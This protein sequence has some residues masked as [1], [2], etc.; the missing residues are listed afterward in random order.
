MKSRERLKQAIAIVERASTI[1]RAI[2]KG[3]PWINVQNQFSKEVQRENFCFFK[4]GRAISKLGAI[5]KKF[6]FL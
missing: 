4:V 2:E 3:L 5:E 1:Q 6:T